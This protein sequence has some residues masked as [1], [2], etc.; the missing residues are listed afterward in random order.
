MSRCDEVARRYRG[1]RARIAMRQA[2]IG[3]MGLRA[4]REA[5]DDVACD[6]VATVGAVVARTSGAAARWS[7]CDEVVRLEV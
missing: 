7:G 3:A 6:C 5:Q 4:P 1:L 2:A